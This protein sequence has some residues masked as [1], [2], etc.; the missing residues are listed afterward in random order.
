MLSKFSTRGNLKFSAKRGTGI[1]ELLPHVSIEGIDLIERLLIYDPEKR[2]KCETA[3][4]HAW[5]DDI[6]EEEDALYVEECARIGYTPEESVGRSRTSASGP[7][8]HSSPRNRGMSQRKEMETQR[9]NKN[10]STAQS[11]K[12]QQLHSL[13]P[14]PKLRVPNQR[15]RAR[16]EVEDSGDEASEE[17]SSFEQSE[18]SSFPLSP[19]KLNIASG[20]Q[21]YLSA[22]GQSRLVDLTGNG[23]KNA[24]GLS[25]QDSW[26]KKSTSISNAVAEAR[27]AMREHPP[28]GLPLPLAHQHK[29]TLSIPRKK[30]TVPRNPSVSWF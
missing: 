14:A 12:N 5:F 29:R 2:I 24:S 23:R 28:Q 27:K 15:A 13:L 9:A 25:S 17:Y 22:Q 3:L 30:T 11:Q 8:A 1:K 20:G 4:Q 26:G 16:N 7:K 21:S 19:S 10:I 18:N 6:R